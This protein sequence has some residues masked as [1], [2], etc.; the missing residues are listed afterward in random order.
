MGGIEGDAGNTGYS[1]SVNG[2]ISYAGGINDLTW[3][4]AN[5]EPIVSCQGDADATVNYNC[6]PGLGNP[7][8]LTLCG[9]GE[10]H[11]IADNLG[12]T[13]NA[14]IFP[15]VGH[16]WGALGS[17]EPKYLQAMDFTTDFLFPL[18]P[19]NNTTSISEK[20][21]RNKQLIRITDILGRNTNT[22]SNGPL[23]YIYDDGSVEK[24]IILN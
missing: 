21:T 23:F 20:N 14:L 16:E 2:V 7:S 18:L 4:D 5:D 1:S 22:I 3:I 11:P 6:G 24:R 17:A 12:I 15:G 10:I 13:N 8:V 19:C 9:T